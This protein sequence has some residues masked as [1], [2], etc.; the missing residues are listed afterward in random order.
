MKDLGRCKTMQFSTNLI[1]KTPIYRRRH[2][3]TKH[4]W[5]LVDERCKEF[6]EIGLIQP[7]CSSFATVTIMLAKKDSTGL[8]TE[9]GRVGIIGL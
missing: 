2:R 1:D 4:E 5:E 3:L 8:W 6:H 9:K 7:S